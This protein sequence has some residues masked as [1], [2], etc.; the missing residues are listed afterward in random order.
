M[1][2]GFNM[3]LIID[4]TPGQA[5]RNNVRILANAANASWQLPA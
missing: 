2:L 1:S 5:D 4:G 3:A